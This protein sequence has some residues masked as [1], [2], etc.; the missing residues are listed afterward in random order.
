MYVN[1]IEKIFCEQI[2]RDVNLST[3]CVMFKHVIYN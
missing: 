2:H 1:P 3:E